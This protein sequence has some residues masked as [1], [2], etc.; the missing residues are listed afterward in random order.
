MGAARSG[1]GWLAHGSVGLGVARLGRGRRRG[2]SD[3]ARSAARRRLSG[4]AGAGRAGRAGAGNKRESRVGER[5]EEGRGT[6]VPGGGLQGEEEDSLVG[7]A[8]EGGGRGIFPLAVAA[9][10]GPTGAT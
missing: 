2:C 10:G 5:R 9:R 7:P 8:R 3:V 4:R 6:W 1:L